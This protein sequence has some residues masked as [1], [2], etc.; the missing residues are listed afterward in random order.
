[1]ADFPM[2]EFRKAKVLDLSLLLIP[3]V[4]RAP[5][6]NILQQMSNFLAGEWD[7]IRG[8]DLFILPIN[9]EAKA[10]GRIKVDLP[11]VSFAVTLLML[12]NGVEFV[13]ADPR[14]RGTDPT[15]RIINFSAVLRGL[16]EKRVRVK[17]LPDQNGDGLRMIMYQRG[18]GTP[19]DM[20]CAQLRVATGL[21][22]S[23]VM[24]CKLFP[25]KY[26]QGLYGGNAGNCYRDFRASAA[27]LVHELNV[28]DPY[29]LC[30]NKHTLKEIFFVLDEF[31]AYAAYT[32]TCIVGYGLVDVATVLAFRQGVYTPM[33]CSG[34]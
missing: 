8:Y 26:E 9:T 13:V 22:R 34:V 17:T 14:H 11:N 31:S 32:A 1:M 7:T 15:V 5:G 4:F 21:N 19:D 12:K 20:T 23:D 27:K 10:Q 16:Q 6:D 3:H 33:K 18:A 24:D 30:M 2:S 25:G 28:V 29:S